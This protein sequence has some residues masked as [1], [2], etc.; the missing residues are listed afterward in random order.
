MP[1]LTSHFRKISSRVSW[2]SLNKSSFI[3]CRTRVFSSSASRLFLSVDCVVFFVEKS[4][5][6]KI[7]ACKSDKSF[8][9]RYEIRFLFKRVTF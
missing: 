5:S 7:T 2:K 4:V 6:F 3:L 8:I 9:P 1:L